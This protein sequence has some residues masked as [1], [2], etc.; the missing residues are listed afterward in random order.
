M[1]LVVAKY[2]KLSLFCSLTGYSDKACRRKMEQGVWVEGIHYRRA[3]DG[4]LMMNLTEYERWVE[5]H[6]A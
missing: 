5:Q 2:V 4:N 6:A 1:P 3:P